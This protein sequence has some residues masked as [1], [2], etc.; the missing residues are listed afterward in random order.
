MTP[1]E[2][3][4][5]LV[6]KFDDENYFSI[7]AVLENSKHNALICVDEIIIAIYKTTSLE[8]ADE[9]VFFWHQVKNEINKL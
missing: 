7:A 6:K 1:K 4:E 8:K 2:K 3:A 5:L 9:L